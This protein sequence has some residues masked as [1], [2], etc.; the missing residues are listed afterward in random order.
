ME[1][2]KPGAK[3]WVIA[4]ALIAGNELLFDIIIFIIS[5]VSFAIFLLQ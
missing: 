4:I 2:Y 3:R 5:M 1:I